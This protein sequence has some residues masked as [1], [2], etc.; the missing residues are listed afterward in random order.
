[1]ESS[2]ET[3]VVLR[4]AIHIQHCGYVV[5]NRHKLPCVQPLT[6]ETVDHYHLEVLD[7][8]QRSRILRR[9]RAIGS[10]VTDGGTS[11]QE[12]TMNVHGND[13]LATV[14]QLCLLITR[15]TGKEI[16]I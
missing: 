9:M 13:C 16:R 2:Q 3:G 8:R 6:E 12:W 15:E 1:M 14:E 11:G 4:A 7:P 5:A 10:L